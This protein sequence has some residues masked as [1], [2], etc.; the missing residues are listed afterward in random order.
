[1]IPIKKI[2]VGPFDY[3]VMPMGKTDELTKFGEHDG[4]TQE[5]RFCETFASNA[6]A[7]ETTI[8]EVLHAIY[9]VMG[10][11]DKDTEERTV[12]LMARG[13]AML[14]RDNPSLIKWI[15]QSLK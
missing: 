10:I 12:L 7:A 6:R 5:L 1:M 9:E 14:I 11:G 13:L 8:H 3:K 2:R 4:N 15:V